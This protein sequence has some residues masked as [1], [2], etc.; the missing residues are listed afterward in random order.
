MGRLTWGPIVTLAH[1]VR[2]ESS[3]MKRFTFLVFLGAV[4]L[5]A[6]S[7]AVLAIGRP[8][9]RAAAGPDPQGTPAWCAAPSTTVVAGDTKGRDGAACSSN[10]EC[11]SDTCE[12]GSCCTDHG[13]TCDSASHCCGHQSC[14]TDGKCP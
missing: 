2:K 8:G 10:S 11:K 13:N 5:F 14:G 1:T 3:T 4:L 6:S 7:S 9:S 12:G